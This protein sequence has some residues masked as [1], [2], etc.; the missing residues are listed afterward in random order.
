MGGVGKCLSHEPTESLTA[1][2]AR[3]EKF[4]QLN[5]CLD[6]DIYQPSRTMLCCN[7]VVQYNRQQS[8]KSKL[9]N[10]TRPHTNAS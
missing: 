5:P 10:L 8:F 3:V 7:N 2:S 1:E 4:F 9:L 6:S